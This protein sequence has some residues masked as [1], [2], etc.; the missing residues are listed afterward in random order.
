MYNDTK[1]KTLRRKLR[2]DSTQ[3]ERMIWNFVRNRQLQGLK[4]FR[5]Y[6]VGIYVLD[7]YCPELRLGVEIDGGQHNEPGVLI[8]DRK[9]ATYLKSQDIKIIRFWNNEV[10]T[11]SEGVY[12]RLWSE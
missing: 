4:F 11:N 2:K 12:E 7:F 10:L 1:L 9:R 5:Q 8:F 3:A 6:G